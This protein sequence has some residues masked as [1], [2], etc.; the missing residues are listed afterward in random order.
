M[1]SGIDV[2][3][4]SSIRSTDKVGTVLLTFQVNPR[5]LAGTRVQ[6]E[7]Q[8]WARWRPIKLRLEACSGAG[9]MLPGSYIMAWT[10]DPNERVVGTMEETV[11]RL[12]S[13]GV[14]AQKPVGQNASLVIPCDATARW[15]VMQGEAV[16]DSHGT[17]LSAL[18]G[19]VGGTTISI[20]WKLHWTIEFNGPDVPVL[21]QDL[22]IHP[23][24]GWENIF[25]DSVSDWAEGARLTF[26]HAEGGS[27]VPW[28]GVQDH[29]VYVPTSGVKIPY[30][31][32][33][34]SAGTVG[35]FS[36]IHAAQYESGL[37]CH[38]TKEDAEAYQKTGD[39]AKVLPWKQAG[40]WCTPASPTLK[41]SPVTTGVLLQPDRVEASG[42]PKSAPRVL[43]KEG[44]TMDFTD[45]SLR[46]SRLEEMVERLVMGSEAS[47][48]HLNSEAKTSLPPS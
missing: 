16:D 37:V 19:M 40:E 34:G 24:A 7:A 35:F 42:F 23:E 25:T 22:L 15:Y 5:A 21:T 14:Q 48:E 12:T 2:I 27:V 10:A 17:V 1:L 44:K 29:V 28:Q 18:S 36:K 6:K 38:A 3:G 39:V 41:G 31:K 46:M 47:F 33:D 20:V 11:A 32:A 26:K 9:L 8:L 13:F 45:F 43:T 4:V 30:Y